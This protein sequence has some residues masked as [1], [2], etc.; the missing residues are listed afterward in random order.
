MEMK[1][2][3]IP[4]FPFGTTVGLHFQTLSFSSIERDG[5]LREQIYCNNI[6]FERFVI[7]STSQR[8]GNQYRNICT[9]SYSCEDFLSMDG[10][11]VEL[12]LI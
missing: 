8:Q 6:C 9:Q 2:H 1:T 10:Y 12:F 7:V 11:N 4:K 3:C 5:N